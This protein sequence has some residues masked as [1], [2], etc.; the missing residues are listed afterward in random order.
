MDD[1]PIENQATEPEVR[2][3]EV[4]HVAGF[5]FEAPPLPTESAAAI[6]TQSQQP[7]VASAHNSP[8]AAA[9]SVGAVPAAATSRSPLRSSVSTLASTLTS[10]AQP[11]G[12]VAK[13][14]FG[15]W[16]GAVGFGVARALSLRSD[17]IEGQGARRKLAAIMRARAEERVAAKRREKA[18]MERLQELEQQI[19]SMQQ[20]SVEKRAVRSIAFLNAN[21]ISLR[22]CPFPLTMTSVCALLL[23]AACPGCF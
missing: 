21:L 18:A 23:C 9:P 19:Q 8:A 16:F 20:Q 1:Q 12:A 14:V 6:D 3:V 11:V 13:T 15:V 4:Q 7:S 17:W 2:G 22:S 10:I 5:T